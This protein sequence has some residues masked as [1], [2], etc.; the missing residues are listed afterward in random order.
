MTI[1]TLALF[2]ASALA[3]AAVWNKS[4]E[5]VPWRIV[6][7]FIA[8]VCAYEATTLFTP[9]VDL[10]GRLAFFV[11]PWKAMHESPARANTGIV[12]TQIAPWTRI[13][14]DAILSGEWPLWNRYSAS[15][16]PLLGNQQT[17]IFHPFTLAG[18][19][20]LSIGKA[21]TYTASIRLFTVL[22]FTFVMLR[23]HGLR[24]AAAVYGAVA[25]T[26]CTFH[27]VWLLFPLGLATM[28]LPVAMTGAQEIARAPRFRAFLLLIAG[29]GLSVLGGHP[30]SAFWVWCV[31]G[32]YSAFLTILAPR[33]LLLS[34]VAFI[35]AAALTAFFWMPTVALLPRMART[36]LMRSIETNPPNHHLGPEWLE[37]LLAP[38]IL[39]T[40]QSGTYV[41]PQQ[42]YLPVL[43]DY[44]EIASGYAGIL[45]LGLAAWAIL[46]V[47]RR[48]VIFFAG[49]MLF[50]FLTIAEVPVWREVVRSVPIAGLTMHQRLRIV[51]VLGACVLS[52]FALD[53]QPDKRQIRIAL[54]VVWASVATVYLI[55]KPTSHV[56]WISFGVTSGVTIACLIGPVAGP[57]ATVL[58]FVELFLVTFGYNP[59]ATPRETFPTTGAIATMRRFRGLHRI[60]ALGYSFPPDTPG[61]Y[62][63]EDIKSTDPVSDPVYKRMVHGFLHVFPSYD[64]LFDNVSEP[65]FDFLNIRYIYVP[66]SMNFS[67]SRF[68]LRYSGPDGK[69]FE[70]L[71]AIPRYFL[72][73]RYR[74]NT[75]I[76]HAI[77]TLKS[78]TDFRNDAV[79]DHVPAKVSDVAP[80]LS[81]KSIEEWMPSAPGTV[82]V[83][84][85]RNNSTTLAVE[86]SGWSLLASSDT[87]WP[88]W[89]AYV[90][91]ERQPPVTVNGAFIGC[92]VPPG[93]N[94]V[95]LRYRPAEFERGLRIG[96][97]AL[98]ALAVTAAARG[99]R[100]A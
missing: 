10:P 93:R 83:Q 58:T 17:A 85:Y 32:A 97:L 69:V 100:R 11:D 8:I 45:T 18:F 73:A 92:F 91:G 19:L 65:Y 57:A 7:L 33:R 47:R 52:A 31:V 76:S 14:R 60:A 55:R 21:F 49:L 36:G 67:D 98:L 66:P 75:A 64:E 88:G 62:G 71:R 81:S 74:V 12:F 77:P 43:D 61:F 27:V 44:G 95:E 54:A 89:R 80:Q 53:A 48:E 40:P 25:Y 56:A 41:P 29:L 1:A 68:A 70:N 16:T 13:A 20:L 82:R 35:V 72:P 34:A 3:I 59:S 28:M 26:F 79:V 94:T 6:V 23:G 46:S 51:W 24:V 50:A 96:V 86:T 78:I 38:N 22:F 4:F 90:N 63:L 9:R 84:S 42:H 99:F 30:E 37:T 5:A 39:G 15:G 2:L 87:H